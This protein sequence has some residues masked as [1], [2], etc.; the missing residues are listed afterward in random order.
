MNTTI[1]IIYGHVHITETVI[2]LVLAGF[3]A[4]VGYV[5]VGYRDSSERMPSSRTKTIALEF[6]VAVGLLAF[7]IWLTVFNASANFRQA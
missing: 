2:A 6:S 3:A 4:V 7:V 1:E 5:A